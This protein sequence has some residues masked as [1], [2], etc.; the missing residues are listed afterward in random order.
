MSRRVNER[1]YLP[2]PECR[3]RVEIP[4]MEPVEVTS[5]TIAGAM[6]QAAQS[7]DLPIRAVRIR[8]TCV[9]VGVADERAADWPPQEMEVPDWPPPEMREPRVRHAS[10]R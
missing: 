6:E 3:W 7:F 1:F 2:E 5:R 9:M 4:G 8:A 10:R